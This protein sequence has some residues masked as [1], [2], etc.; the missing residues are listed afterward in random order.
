MS[1]KKKYLEKGHTEE[2][3]KR[4][5]S[6][7]GK[8]IDFQKKL[9]KL[10]DA[11]QSPWSIIKRMTDLV[12][13]AIG[14]SDFERTINTTNP[15]QLYGNYLMYRNFAQ[16]TGDHLGALANTL[17]TVKESCFVRWGDRNHITP[18]IRKNW[19]SENSIEMDVIAQEATGLVGI[20]VWPEDIVEFI[21][22]HPGGVKT[23]LHFERCEM[24]ADAF[25]KLTGFR[26]TNSFIDRFNHE[27]LK[28]EPIEPW[29]DVPF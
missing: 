27:Y 21:L 6:K 25:Y 14:P 26:L 11:C 4:W 9:R 3:Y 7:V 12:D 22:M 15:M 18:E 19:F 2:Q 10:V 29:E 24:L 5:A 23:Y 28:R 8:E 17:T 1:S 13:R 16:S 20:P